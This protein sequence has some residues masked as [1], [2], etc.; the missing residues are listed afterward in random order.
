MGHLGKSL[1]FGWAKSSNYLSR[2]LGKQSNNLNELNSS[3]VIREHLGRWGGV[4]KKLAEQI[5]I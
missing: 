3:P 4:L 2:V 5:Q 1:F